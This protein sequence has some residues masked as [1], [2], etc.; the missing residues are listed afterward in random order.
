MNQHRPVTVVVQAPQT[1]GL[2]T[3]GFIVSLISFFCLGLTSPVGLFLSCL[4]VLSRPR[5]MAFAGVVLGALGS[6]WLVAVGLA[7]LLRLA[8]VETEPESPA[9]I[10]R[11]AEPN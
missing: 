8:G 6:W 1:N 7:I 11:P 4:G 9:E 3:A 5:G 10:T 2:G